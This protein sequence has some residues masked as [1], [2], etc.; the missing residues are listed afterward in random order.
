MTDIIIQGIGGRMGHVLC[1]MIA[2]R[3]DCRVVAGIDMR[4]G[5]M[6][7]IPVYDSLD[8]LD[9]KGDVVIDFSAPAAVEKA[10]PYCEAHKLPIVVCTTGLSEELQL[11]I[12]QLSRS[13]PVFKSANMSM[14]INVLSELCKRASAILGANY[15]IEI[16]E[17][18]HHNKL[19]AP[20][21]TALMLADAI[22]EENDGA[23]HY[24]YDRSSVRQKRD[25]KEIGIS[26]VRGGSIVGDHEVLFCAWHH[27]AQYRASGDEPMAKHAAS[28]R[29]RHSAQK[30]T[31]HKG[32][33]LYTLGVLLVAVSTLLSLRFWPRRIVDAV[34]PAAEVESPAV[35][36]ELAV[37][38]PQPVVTTLRFSATGDNLIHEPIYSQ[39]ARRAAEGEGYSFDYCYMNLLDFYAQQD[40]NWINQETLCSKELAPSTYPCFSTP[41]ECA[42]ALYRAGF[43]VFSLSNN[44][45]Y[46]KGAAG[47]AATLRFW[48]TMPEDVITTGLWKGEADYGRIPIQTVDG[49]KIAYLSYTEHT[50]G[51]PRNSKMAANIIY[52]SQQ[53]VMEQQ[54]RAARQ[55]ADFVVV[56]VHWGVEDSHNITQAQ[57][58]LAQSLADWGA[59]VIIG[60]HPHVLQDAE[61]RTAADGRNVFVAYSLGNFLSTQSKPDQLFG[62]ILTLDLEQT[63]EPDGS[64][65]CA[66]R[67]PKL[68]VTVTHYDAGKSNVR[69]YLFRDYTPELAQ[70]HGVRAAYPSFGYDYIRQTAQTYINSEFLEL[71]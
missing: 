10:L 63:T 34:P 18:H 11:K 14:G 20:S 67:G 21:G 46:D 2:Q 37:P 53:D 51:I 29:R 19:D 8:K 59:D 36:E 16:V 62:A 33:T 50:N 61:W 26:A 39:A 56:G 64:V 3:E 68:H 52:T 57:R 54:V 1:E 30:H 69:T 5:E 13:I 60:T 44:H 15:D 27:K 17:Q 23:Y 40:I 70:A 45:T 42:E 35:S 38:E 28:P 25:P 48:E 49:V 12:V 4:D 58:T 43:R 31:S 47:I 66:V 7:G 32:V 65:H 41:G 71:A 22:N 24:V 6:N 55:E 9:G